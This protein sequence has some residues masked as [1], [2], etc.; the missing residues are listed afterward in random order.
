MGALS[1]A[2]TLALQTGARNLH[3]P[4]PLFSLA[5]NVI[6]AGALLGL[7]AVLLGGV[8]LVVSAWRSTPRSR[9]LFLVPFLTC[10]LAILITILHPHL[11]Y[12]DNTLLAL[13]F[14]GVPLIGT[15]AINRAIRQAEIS[16]ESLRFATIPSR[17]V[18]L[19]M[20]LMLVGV[21]L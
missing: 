15:I 7:G 19:G 20:L 21:I 18:V 6:F 14:Y 13:T 1:M 8:P 9:F 2:L 17:L 12:N 4:Q 16:D 5:G 3:M 11:M 10:G